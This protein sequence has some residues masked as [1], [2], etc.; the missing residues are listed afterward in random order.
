MILFT[1]AVQFTSASFV[2]E[3]SSCDTPYNKVTTAM[4]I[5]DHHIIEE[6]EPTYECSLQQE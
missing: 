2:N 3:V 6:A 1:L 4:T 5:R